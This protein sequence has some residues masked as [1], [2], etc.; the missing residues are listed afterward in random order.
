M[1]NDLRVT[2]I[3]MSVDCHSGKKSTNY[4]GFMDDYM[5]INMQWVITN[6]SEK[7]Q[8]ER[9]IFAAHNDKILI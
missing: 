6:S 4:K 9:F 7:F 8:G 3:L 2:Y 1:T 5:M